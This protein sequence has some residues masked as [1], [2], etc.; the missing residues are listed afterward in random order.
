MKNAIYLNFFKWKL[1]VYL[2]H[3]KLS[4]CFYLI[5]WQNKYLSLVS[6]HFILILFVL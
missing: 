3:G 4:G 1:V 2:E 6:Y 5:A